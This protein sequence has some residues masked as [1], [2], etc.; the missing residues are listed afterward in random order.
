MKRNNT[1]KGTHIIHWC[2]K[3]VKQRD[4]LKYVH[5]KK[6]LITSGL[7]CKTHAWQCFFSHS[8][9][10][11]SGFDFSSTTQ[12]VPGYG[13]KFSSYFCANDFGTNLPPK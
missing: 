6:L 12:S 9:P 5:N 7:S 11:V 8:L 4:T 10:F 1:F 3:S 2:E 13:G